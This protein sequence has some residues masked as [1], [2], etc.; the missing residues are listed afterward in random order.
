[1]VR[2]HLLHSLQMA[3]TA[4]QH[5]GFVGSTCSWSA[6]SYKFRQ[7]RRDHPNQNP[8]SAVAGLDSSLP[9]LKSTTMT[10]YLPARIRSIIHFKSILEDNLPVLTDFD[11]QDLMS[12]PVAKS[13]MDTPIVT[14]SKTRSREQFRIETKL[15]DFEPVSK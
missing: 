7:R 8:P 12:N 9:L 15:N 3:H 10:D 1:M 6:V 5:Q 2:Q 4:L 11:P 14:P 13:V